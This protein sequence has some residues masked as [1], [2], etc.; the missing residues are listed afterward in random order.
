MTLTD[1]EILACCAPTSD[2]SVSV[3]DRPAREL[4][5][6]HNQIIGTVHAGPNGVEAFRA[7]DSL[8]ERSAARVNGSGSFPT[9]GDGVR[10]LIADYC[11]RGTL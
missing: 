3:Y 10:A 9:I 8:A 5:D 6:P 1:S 7:H 4:T 2:H 11:A